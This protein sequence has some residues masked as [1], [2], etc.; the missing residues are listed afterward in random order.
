MPTGFEP[1]YFT[2]GSFDHGLAKAHLTVAGDNDLTST[3][4]AY[5]RC[6]MPAWKFFFRHDQILSF[7]PI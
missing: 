4:Y 2:R 5:D 6:A 7:H 1:A 3:T